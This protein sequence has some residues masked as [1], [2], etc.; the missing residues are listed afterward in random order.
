MVHDLK[1]ELCFL[2]ALGDH[3]RGFLLVEV[4]SFLLVREAGELAFRSGVRGNSIEAVLDCFD[5]VLRVEER[6][7]EK[8]TCDKHI[9][10]LRLVILA[11]ISRYLQPTELYLRIFIQFR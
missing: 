11:H 7:D 8:P 4:F 5:H 6:I 1:C 9:Y 10:S 3:E 2:S